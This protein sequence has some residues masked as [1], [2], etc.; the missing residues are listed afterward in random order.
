M[1]EDKEQAP[2]KATNETQPPTA[3]SNEDDQG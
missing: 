1:P 3:R 2:E